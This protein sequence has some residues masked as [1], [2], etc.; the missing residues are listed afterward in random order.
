MPEPPSFRIE[1]APG[2]GGHVVAIHGDL[3]YNTAPRLERALSA[4]DGRDSI[5][6]DM[7]GVTLLDSSGLS[8]LV[9]AHLRAV[10]EGGSLTIVAPPWPVMRILELTGV[11]PVLDVR[12]AGT[13]IRPAAPPPVA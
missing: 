4:L 7:R 2:A 10:R 1:T 11:A 9:A 12:D 8:V 13:A 6:L 5:A 3:E